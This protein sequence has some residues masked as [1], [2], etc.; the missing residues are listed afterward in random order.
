MVSAPSNAIFCVKY[1]K[2]FGSGIV[3]IPKKQ[4]VFYYSEFGAKHRNITLK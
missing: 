2:I 1:C 4:R 3:I